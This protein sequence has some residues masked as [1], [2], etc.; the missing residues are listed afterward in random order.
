MKTAGL[1][2]ITAITGDVQKNVNFY[3]GFLGQRFVKKTVNFD[4]PSS[5]HLYYGDYVGSPGTALTFFSWAHLPKRTAGYGEANAWYYRILKGSAE[6]WIDRAEEFSVPCERVELHQ[7]EALLLTD[8]DGY[9]VYLV[10]VKNDEEPPLQFWLDGP[11]PLQHQLRGFYGIHLS[12]LSVDSVAPI[13]TEVFGYEEVGKEGKVTRFVVPST[14]GQVVD[15]EE[16]YDAPRAIQGH[17]SIHHVAFRAKDSEEREA[18]RVP[19]GNLGV[20]STEAVE[21]IFFEATYFW[22]PAGILFEISTD[23]PGFTINEPAEALGENMI[24]PPW[25]EPHRAEI[26]AHLPPITLP[27]HEKNT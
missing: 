23:S 5:Y 25:Y 20:S 3:E 10:E 27:R 9:R 26:V 6:Y 1:H 15:V 24:L 16:V 8:P 21:R 22:T 7:E 12:V 17:G 4:D 19:L 13:L 11:V 14:H 18:F 2:H